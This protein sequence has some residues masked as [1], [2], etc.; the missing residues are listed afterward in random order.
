MAPTRETFLKIKVFQIFLPI[1]AAHANQKK[2]VKQERLYGSLGETHV[3]TNFDNSL[4][5][6]ANQS[7]LGQILFEL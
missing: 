4:S 3:Q 2:V 6:G 1:K 5:N 7:A